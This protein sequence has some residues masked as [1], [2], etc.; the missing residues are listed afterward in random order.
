MEI[1]VDKVDDSTVIWSAEY[2]VGL[3]GSLLRVL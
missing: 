1:M 3:I 2:V